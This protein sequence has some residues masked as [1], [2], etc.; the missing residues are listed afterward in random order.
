MAD[1]TITPDAPYEGKMGCLK[2]F[3]PGTLGV[4]AIVLGTAANVFCETI[5]FTQN[6]GH[7]DLT[8]YAGPFS[9]RTK[10]QSEWPDGS[11]YIYTT[12]R[13]YGYLEDNYGFNY[14]VDATTKAV[15]SF[16]IMTP[17][18]GAFYI[19]CACLAPCVTN[20]GESRWKSLGCLLIT[21]SIFQ[22]I[23][24]MVQSSSICNNNPTLQY[25]NS[26]D[27]TGELA[28]TFPTT[29]E[30]AT[31]YTLNIIA[32]VLWFLAGASCY[33]FPAPIVHAERPVQEQTVT[34]QQNPDGTVAETNVVIQGKPVGREEPKEHEMEA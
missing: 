14:Y 18:L 11:T 7:D 29:C 4:C 26:V 16:A 15:W 2:A 23:T 1:L 21:L 3:L 19:L 12:C 34:Y 28:G 20:I 8:L 5:K 27:P 31:G 6:P 33:V 22:G 24:L 13:Y 17:I 32:V 10:G 30:W 25:I 9:Y